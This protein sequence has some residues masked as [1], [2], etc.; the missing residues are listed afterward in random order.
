[1]Y[2][3]FFSVAFDEFVNDLLEGFDDVVLWSESF[4]GV[5]VKAFE[6]DSEVEEGE[7][8]Y[9]LNEKLFCPLSAEVVDAGDCYPSQTFNDQ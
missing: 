1:V 7:T 5:R 8:L 3:Y 6:A 9:C 4:V 2:P